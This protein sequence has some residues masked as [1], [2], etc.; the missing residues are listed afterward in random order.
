MN[1]T[2]AE[3]DNLRKINDQLRAE[4]AEMTERYARLTLEHA[5]TS[6]ELDN[7]KRANDDTTNKMTRLEE[8]HHRVCMK[9]DENERTIFQYRTALDVFFER[10]VNYDNRPV[11]DEIGL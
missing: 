3:F 1:Y 10:L 9:L 7:A 4:N 6:R 2:Q 5:K 11:I 8:R